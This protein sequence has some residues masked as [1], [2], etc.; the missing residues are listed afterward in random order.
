MATMIE[1]QVASIQKELEKLQK[2]LET[3]TARLEKKIAKVKDL[4]CEWSSEEWR[5]RNEQIRERHIGEAI[6]PY[7]SDDD[8][9]T[10]KQSEAWWNWTSEIGEVEDLKGKI[11]R[12]KSRLEKMTGK[13][14]I[15]RS[16]IEAK[17][18]RMRSVQGLKLLD[19]LQ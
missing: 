15:Q 2:S 14:E 16:E 12:T 18:Q 6:I 11:E 17:Q 9:I 1:K 3:H 7:G 4:N 19:E 13:F 10:A 8:L 5:S